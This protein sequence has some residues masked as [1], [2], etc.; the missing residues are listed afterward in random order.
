MHTWENTPIHFIDFEGTLAEGILEYGVVSILN[1]TIQAVY[2]GLCRPLQ[3]KALG[4]SHLHG[5]EG[6]MLEAQ[7]PFDEYWEL[8]SSLRKSGILAA[9]NASVEDQFLRSVWPFHSQSPDF[10]GSSTPTWGP[11]VDT[12]ALSRH[13]LKLKSY[14][15]AS[16]VKH[17]QLEGLLQ[18]CVLQ[19]CPPTR[20]HWHSALHDALAGAILLLYLVQAVFKGKVSLAE[21]VFHS[22]R[23]LKLKHSLQQS[24]I[25]LE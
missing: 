18:D 24:K 4:S 12:Y 21:L 9:H 7:P 10:Q 13:Y 19:H 23:S 2:T 16:T 11:W 8:F 3:D 17:L 15:L 20:R 25:E 5:L 6:P 22:H 1:G 14:R